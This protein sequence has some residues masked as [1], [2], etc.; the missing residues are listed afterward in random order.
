MKMKT[1]NDNSLGM[2]DAEAMAAFME[3]I[4]L[5]FVRDNDAYSE[6]D[7]SEPV[8]IRPVFTTEGIWP[9][10]TVSMQGAYKCNCWIHRLLERIGYEP[11]LIWFN[12]N[13]TSE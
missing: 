8:Y 13:S 11:K 1:A 4:R 7:M 12:I 5:G 2:T 9:S 3:N 10:G 6:A